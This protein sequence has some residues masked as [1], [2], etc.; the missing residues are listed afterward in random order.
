MIIIINAEK[1]LDKNSIMIKTLRKIGIE[2]DLLN[3]IKEHL[4]KPTNDILFHVK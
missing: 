3:L 4:Q 1:A 2:E